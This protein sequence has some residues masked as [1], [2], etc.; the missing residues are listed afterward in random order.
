M[1]AGIEEY[2]NGQP[3]SVKWVTAIS[4]TT[5]MIARA[6]RFPGWTGPAYSIP[7]RSSTVDWAGTDA[8]RAPVLDRD[9]PVHRSWIE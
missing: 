8:A 2:A 9:V 7:T 6:S 1:K 5:A 3:G 4:G